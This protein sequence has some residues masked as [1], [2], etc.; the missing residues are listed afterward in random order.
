MSQ[1]IKADSTV[2]TSKEQVSCDLAGETAIL[3]VKSG[4]YYGLDEVG[5][6]VWELIQSPRRVS[7]VRDALLEEYDVDPSRCEADLVTLLEQLAETELIE[8]RA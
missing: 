8:T 7:E 2:V 4:V 6:R 5:A 1:S 3:N